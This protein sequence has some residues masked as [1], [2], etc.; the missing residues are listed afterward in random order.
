[1]GSLTALEADFGAAPDRAQAQQVWEGA[2]PGTKMLDDPEGVATK[3]AEDML[4][5]VH[6]A[7]S[8][9]GTAAVERGGRT[10][11]KVLQD[12]E[13]SAQAARWR[14]GGGDRRMTAILA[15]MSGTVIHLMRGPAHSNQGVANGAV[16]VAPRPIRHTSA[17]KRVPTPTAE[18]DAGTLA[19]Q[20]ARWKVILFILGLL[21]IFF[22][23]I[24]ALMVVI[25]RLECRAVMGLVIHLLKELWTQAHLAAT[26]M[27]DH[28]AVWLYD[29]LGMV[30]PVGHSPSP[31]PKVTN[32][33]MPP[34]S[35]L[36][37]RAMQSHP[38]RL[39]DCIIVI[40]GLN[41][42][43]RPLVGGGWGGQRP[44]MK[45]MGE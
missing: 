9:M 6:S 35:E 11:A 4:K 29:Q 43:C 32:H 37:L 24:V 12:P 28:V 2:F 5:P 25:M 1:M 44:M 42:R 23:R 45:L 26:E 21:T 33:V 41:L 39:V 40:L 31:P 13:A 16:P 36:A 30:L 10:P 3:A 27:E 20:P 8:R 34:Q 22:P 17:L 15:R 38:T 14:S 19:W 18:A 7:A